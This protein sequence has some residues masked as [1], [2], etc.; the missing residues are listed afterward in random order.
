MEKGFAAQVVVRSRAYLDYHDPL[1]G[2]P[3][4]IHTYLTTPNERG[5]VL[6]GAL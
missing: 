6:P 4:Y 3:L 5:Y 2:I 1:F